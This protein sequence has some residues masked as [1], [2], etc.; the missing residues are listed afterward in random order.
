MPVSSCQQNRLFLVLFASS[1]TYK[2]EGILKSL[3]HTGNCVLQ[4]DF[5]LMRMVVLLFLLLFFVIVVVED[6]VRVRDSAGTFSKPFQ[7]YE[8]FCHLI[9]IFCLSGDMIVGIAKYKQYKEKQI[10]KLT[11]FHLRKSANSYQKNKIYM[12]L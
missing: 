12:V 8:V 9:I 4:M 2:R 3:C 1:G 6:D 11:V 7:T 5:I 10:I